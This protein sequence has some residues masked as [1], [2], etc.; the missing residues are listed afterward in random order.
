M[1]IEVS[2]VREKKVAYGTEYEI[3]YTCPHCGANITRKHFS[4][5]LISFSSEILCGAICPECGA[6]E[7]LEIIH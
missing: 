3:S 5:D 2:I 6:I 1:T 7:D 4:L